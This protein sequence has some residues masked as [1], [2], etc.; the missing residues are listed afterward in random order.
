MV[1]L[2]LYADFNNADELGR[3]RLNGAGTL[4][5]LARFG[6]PLSE[7]LALT[8]HDEELAADG[9]AEYSPAEK[10][11]AARIDWSLTRRAHEAAESLAR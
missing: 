2:N 3:V 5:D 11:W 4:R 6:V 1:P 9:V 10:V 8:V 7:G